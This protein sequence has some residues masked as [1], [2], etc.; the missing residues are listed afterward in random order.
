M[1][2][3]PKEIRWSEWTWAMTSF[4]DMSELRKEPYGALAKK[5]GRGRPPAGK[6]HPWEVAGFSRTTYYRLKKQGKL[7]HVEG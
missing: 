7:P 5:R 1:D 3:D 6:A 2:D 4:E